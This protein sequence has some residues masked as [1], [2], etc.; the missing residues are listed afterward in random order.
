VRK[1]S[2]GGRF[3]TARD[4]RRAKDQGREA[5]NKVVAICTTILGH[6]YPEIKRRA[7]MGRRDLGDI[8][9][10]TA[11]TIEVKNSAIRMSESVREAETEGMNAKTADRWYAF[12]RIPSAPVSRW[13]AVTHVYVV[14]DMLKR[15]EEQRREIIRLNQI[16]AHLTP[17]TRPHYDAT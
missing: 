1:T 17:D 10:I 6:L 12:L 8:D 3:Q 5:E 13:Y 2:K 9:G 11:V 4:S 15:E 7:K 14:L 16:V